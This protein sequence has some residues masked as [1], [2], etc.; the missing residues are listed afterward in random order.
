MT[1]PSSFDDIDPSPFL[2]NSEKASLNSAPINASYCTVN[3]HIHERC[4]ETAKTSDYDSALD[5]TY[6]AQNVNNDTSRCCFV[7]YSFFLFCSS[8]N[9]YKSF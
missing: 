3:L 6:K 4:A 7:P 9:I 8:A 2:S 5:D 1:M